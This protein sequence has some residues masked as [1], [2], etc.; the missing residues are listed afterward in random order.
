MKR[1]G[2]NHGGYHGERIA[3]DDMLRDCEAMAR[4]RGWRG[5]QVEAAPGLDLQA[6]HRKA[7]VLP[8]GSVAP[9]LYISA[10][11]HGDEPA[12]PLAMLRLLAEDLLPHEVDLWVWPCLN[13]A[14]FRAGT[15]A[16][17]EGRDLNRDYRHP[18][19]LE[20]RAHVAWLGQP[21]SFDLA[22]CLHEDWEAHGF[23]LYELN[24][25]SLPSLAEPMI[26]EVARV[27]PIDP[28]TEI[29]GRVAQGGIIRPNLDPAA[30][31]EWPEAFYLIQNKTRQSYTLEAPSDFPL[32][33]RVNALVTAV[34]SAMHH[35]LEPD[36]PYYRV[37]AV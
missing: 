21:R 35:W 10:G 32:E 16:N 7:D 2:K 27:C 36:R 15:R 3:L 22:F 34:Q 26:R 1:L 17:A 13:P 14:G 4:A 33:V 5:E 25:D 31:P 30:R 9:R 23:Y 29:E 8:E 12:G 20:I 6:F 28:S 24:P 19:S 11:I 37:Y 18:V